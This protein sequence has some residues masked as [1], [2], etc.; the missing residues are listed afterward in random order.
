MMRSGIRCEVMTSRF[1][2]VMMNGMLL[3]V[4]MMSATSGSA[5]APPI[6]SRFTRSMAWAHKATSCCSFSRRRVAMLL[7]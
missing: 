5:M 1:S 2:L 7:V 4:D 3:L 6:A